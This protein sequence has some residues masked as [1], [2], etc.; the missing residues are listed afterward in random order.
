VA[1][2]VE[3]ATVDAARARLSC[4]PQLNVKSDGPLDLRLDCSKAVATAARCSGSVAFRLPAV[5]GRRVV[6][7]IVSRKGQRLKT[8]KGRNLRSV[9]LRRVSRK[10]FSVRLRLRTSGTGAGARTVTVVRRVAAC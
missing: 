6:S 3:S 8:V 1:T 2:N 10:A 4:A 5:R 7:V 9:S